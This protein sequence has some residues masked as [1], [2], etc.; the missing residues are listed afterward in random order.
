MMKRVLAFFSGENR[1]PRWLRWLPLLLLALAPLY[2]HAARGHTET[3]NHVVTDNDQKV[4]LRIAQKLKLTDYEYFTPRQRTPGFSYLISPFWKAEYSEGKKTSSVSDLWFET[5]KQINIRLSLILLTALSV[6]F[7]YTIGGAI[8]AMMATLASGFLLYV[9]RAGYTQPELL[10]WT[11]N[12]IAYYL[13]MRMLWAPTWGLAVAGGLVSA[14]AYFVKAGTQPLLLLFVVS[15]GV[16]LVWDW[17]YKKKRPAIST[18]LKGAL[19]PVIFTIALFPYLRGSFKEFGDPFYSTYSKYIMW[20]WAGEDGSDDEDDSK[21]EMYAIMNAGAAD[22]K[23]TEADFQKAWKKLSAEPPPEIPTFGRY[24]RQHTTGEIAKRPIDGLVRNHKRLEKY[25]P[26]AYLF[27]QWLLWSALLI[28]VLNFRKLRPLARE[29]LPVLFYVA[30]FFIGYLILYGW[31]DG[32]RIG[33]RLILSLYV[34]AVFTLIWFLWKYAADTMVTIKGQRINVHRCLFSI[35]AIV[36]TC[37]IFIVL[38][39]EL[40]ANFSGA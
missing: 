34:P 12:V 26:S 16:K 4:Y 36:L 27:L 29:N 25:Y 38:T 24:L 10:Y 1:T 21:N 6:F 9:F 30:G 32:L 2:M 17:I 11:L 31:Y 3:F 7:Y 8:P 15:Y 5:G 37:K 20:V 18:V 28:I 14:A 39:S 13:L 35:L 23:I 22:H 40:Y 19:V 33:A